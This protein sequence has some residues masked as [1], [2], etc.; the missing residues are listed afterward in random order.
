MG[1]VDGVSNKRQSNSVV[2]VILEDEVDL[3]VGKIVESF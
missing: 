1:E 3:R 2:C